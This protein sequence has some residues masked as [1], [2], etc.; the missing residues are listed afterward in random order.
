MKHPDEFMQELLDLEEEQEINN[1]LS[2][3]TALTF[4][5]KGLSKSEIKTMAASAIESVFESGNPLKIAEALSA[6]ELFIKEVKDDKKFK[7]YVREE[8]AKTP[9]GFISNSGAKV[10]LFEAGTTYD[11]SNCADP[12]LN[13][14][15]LAI[16][17]AKVKAEERKTFLKALPL[18]GMDIITTEGEVVKVYPPAKSSVSSYKITLAK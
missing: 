11:F 5:E 7:E 8:A 16:D 9:K 4:F 18:S 15:N 6:M 1:F 10:E 17:I 3:S 2:A 13:E 12:V 14:L